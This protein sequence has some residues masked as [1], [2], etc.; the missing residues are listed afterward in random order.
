MVRI[1]P[2]KH[3]GIHYTKFQSKYIIISKIVHITKE[4]RITDTDIFN[5]YLYCFQWDEY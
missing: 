3:I 4:C 2:I 5:F 1:G